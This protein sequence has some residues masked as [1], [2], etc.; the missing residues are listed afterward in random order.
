MSIIVASAEKYCSAS[1]L[2]AVTLSGHERIADALDKGDVVH[3]IGCADR[4]Q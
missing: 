1:A 2:P 3:G 4:R